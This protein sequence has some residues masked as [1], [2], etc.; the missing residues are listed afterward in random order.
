M[1]R[2]IFFLQLL[3]FV[4]VSA[5]DPFRAY[6]SSVP[7]I[8]SVI[9]D[10]LTGE[11][12]EAIV[13]RKITFTSRNGA[14][15]VYAVMAFPAREGK[16][17][18]MLF[19]HGGGSRAEDMLGRVQDYARRGYVALAPDLPGICGNGKTPHS[20]GPWKSRPNGEAPRFDLANGPESSTLADAIV[21][22]LEAFNL[23]RSRPDVDV[24]H[25]GITGFSWGGYS[26]T[27]LTGLLGNKVQAAYSVFGSGFYDLGSFWKEI[28]AQL[29]E[30]DRKTWLQYFDAGRRA[31]NIKAPFFM[32]AASNDT[33]FWPEAVMATLGRIKGE[34]NLVWGPNINHKQ[35]PGGGKMQELYFDY[36]LKGKGQPFGKVEAKPGKKHVTIT[37]RMPKGI[38]VDSVMLYCAAPSADWQHKKW[39]AVPAQKS[40]KKYVA[41]IPAGS[42]H[43][44]AYVGD[45]RGVALASLMHGPELLLPVK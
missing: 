31:K 40:G 32:E 36:Y 25:M 18:G 15:T 16:Y 19:L 3:W 44:F 37:V 11:G 14:N 29:P 9:G 4:P 38:T 2:I 22:G 30:A 12:A 17:P 13:T 35:I 24:K 45:S 42:D 21:A 34:K 8:V 20:T 28:I 26:T 39:T 23:L 1:K 10:T 41:E 33:Y 27:M 43:W 7:E 5:Q 6:L